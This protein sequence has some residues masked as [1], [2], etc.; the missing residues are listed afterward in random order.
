MTHK[1][2]NRYLKEFKQQIIDFYN[3][4]T[5]VVKLDSEYDVIEQTIALFSSH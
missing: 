4:G 3:A 5:P 2:G 1:T